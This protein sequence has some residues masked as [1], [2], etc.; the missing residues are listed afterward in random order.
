M[1]A[2]VLTSA[3]A[4]LI[5][6]H[7]VAWCD[8]SLPFEAYLACRN[9]PGEECPQARKETDQ[10]QEEDRIGRPDP[11]IGM[12]SSQVKCETNWGSPNRVNTT[13]TANGVTE[14]WV[15]TGELRN[16]ILTP[17]AR[18][19]LYFRDGLLYAIQK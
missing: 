19:Y 1:R 13:T 15:Y 18:G 5:N 11:Q 7:A 9:R 6:G 2:T 16:R 17:Q 10:E 4:C 8:P 12:T 3:L 14:Q